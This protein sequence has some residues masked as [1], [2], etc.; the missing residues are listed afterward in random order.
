MRPVAIVVAAS[1]TAAIAIAHAEPRP[2]PN[3]ARVA[4]RPAGDVPS[5]GPADALVTVELFFIPGTVQSRGP[6]RALVA[7]QARHPR[8]LRLLLRPLSRQGM[9]LVPEAVMEAHAQG[10]FF[11]LLD[12]ISASP[13][14][15]SRQEVLTVAAQVGVDAAR[16]AQ[17]WDDERHKPALDG[18]EV[19][20]QRHYALSV[21]DAL[22][23]GMP[24]ARPLPSLADGDLEAAYQD[25][26]DRAQEL[27]DDGVP[28]HALAAAF[29]RELVRP[30]TL[31]VPGPVDGSPDQPV[32]DLPPLAERPLD[33]AG[34]PSIGPPSAAVPVLVLCDLTQ[35]TCL[36]QV[37][38]AVKTAALF[39]DDVR[40]L[41]SPWYPRDA[42]DP[43]AADEVA[44]A[45][46]CAEEQGSGWDWVDKA[47]ERTQR[48]GAR[49][50]DAAQAI[51]EVT[52]EA[53][54]D[55]RALATCMARTPPDRAHDKIEDAV[56]RGVRHGPAI[57]VGGRV[58]M[59]GVSEPRVLQG[60]IE[61]E[62]EPGL[63]GK[64]APDWENL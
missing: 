30:P 42:A 20:R 36:G 55:T 57:I 47:L 61:D 13:R 31:F 21:P 60:L 3:I 5:I 8:R 6:Y 62:L 52:D 10:R 15:L 58:Y 16:V 50:G 11:E 46:L 37:R 40:V 51:R 63:I 39:P 14:T 54:A 24:V 2:P 12:A 1:L 64:A 9:I 48:L 38:N 44:R 25:A 35:R 27:L 18:N 29:D 28:R 43:D 49:W 56:A 32:P 59:G 4:H 7:L 41:W 22:F 19:R 53:G 17:A 45:A 23:N 26:Y 33:L 34:L